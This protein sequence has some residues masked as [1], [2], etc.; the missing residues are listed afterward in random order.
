MENFWGMTEEQMRL[1]VESNPEKI[2]EKD[3]YA[4]SLL[5][6]AACEGMSPPFISWL[7]DKGGDV[8]SK[9]SGSYQLSPLFVAKTAEV[10]DILLKQGG[11]NTTCLNSWQ[12][13]PPHGSLL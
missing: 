12:M 4:R 6:V 8:N 9:N 3:A 10:V 5:Y 1:Y 7:V 2:N 11:A 13:N